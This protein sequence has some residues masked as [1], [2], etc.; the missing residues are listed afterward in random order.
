MKRGRGPQV[1]IAAKES[2]KVIQS[3]VPVQLAERLKAQAELERRSVSSTIR[4]AIE[5]KLRADEERRP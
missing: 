3:W 2:G 4:L 1:A 5:S